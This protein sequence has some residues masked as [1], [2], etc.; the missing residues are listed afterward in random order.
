MD[1]EAYQAWLEFLQRERARVSAELATGI[2]SL[3][4]VKHEKGE[5]MRKGADSG[6]SGAE[7]RERLRAVDF[8]RATLGLSGFFVSEE[9]E[10][11]ARRYVNGEIDLAELLKT[12]P[13]RSSR[14]ED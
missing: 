13:T 5:R 7:R 11:L 14:D 1:K 2:K 3:A 12:P 8:A 4:V 10:S 6:I 9:R